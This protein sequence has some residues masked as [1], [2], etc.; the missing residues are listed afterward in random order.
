[1][2]FINNLSTELSTVVFTLYIAALDSLIKERF[3]HVDLYGYA[4]DHKLAITCKAGNIESEMKAKSYIET[5][6]TDVINW[7]SEHK[8]KMN[9]S[10]TEI[11]IYGTKLQVQKSNIKNIAVG[12]VNVNCVNSVRD[13]G[14]IM[15]NTLGFDT[16][17]KK[18]CQIAS[19]QLKNL[20]NI[21]HYLSQSATVTLIH[22]LVNSHLDFCNGIF[23]NIPQYQLS[24]LQRIQN[25]AA[26]I[27]CNAKYDQPAKP[28]L[29]SLHW[30][31]VEARIQFKVLLLVYKCINNTA[32]VYLRQLLNYKRSSTYSLRSADATL[33][34]IPVVKTKIAER[35]FSFAGPKLWNALPSELR[36]VAIEESFRRQLKTHLFNR[37]Y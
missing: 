37:F 11:I 22:G 5:C 31:P 19:Y 10:K 1:M 35:A 26:R 30:L 33:L 7:M 2:F 3:P 25:R 29:H 21:R 24:R 17:I 14:V 20:K 32:P 18:K 23:S 36:Q 16:H 15:E 9:N 4:D 28:L 6:L 12:E 13:L 27:I 34:E 8:L